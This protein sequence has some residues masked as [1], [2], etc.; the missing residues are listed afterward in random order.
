MLYIGPELQLIQYSLRAMP[1]LFK[2]LYTVAGRTEL[3]FNSI[4]FWLNHI[5]QLKQHIHQYI[6][7]HVDVS[8]NGAV[9]VQCTLSICVCVFVSRTVHVFNNWTV[10]AER[11]QVNTY[12]PYIIGIK[13]QTFLSRVECHRGKNL[14]LH[15]PLNTEGGGPLYLL[16]YF[17]APPWV[18]FYRLVGTRLHT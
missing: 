16:E 4:W 17:S 5:H 18:L 13:C 2:H 8:T 3:D 10:R 15:R 1:Y 7:S 6:S 14:L 11:E 12:I 9:W